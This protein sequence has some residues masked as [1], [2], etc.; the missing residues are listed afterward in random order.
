MV[1]TKFIAISNESR[2]NMLV[3][4]RNAEQACCMS[5]ILS[6]AKQYEQQNGKVHVWAYGRNRLY[7][8]YKNSHFQDMNVCEGIEAISAAIKAVKE[9]IEKKIAGNELYILIGMEQICS[10]FDL[11]DFTN[12]KKSNSLAISNTLTAKSEEQIKALEDMH[13][14]YGELENAIDEMMM[15]WIEKGKSNEEIQEEM[16]RMTAEFEKNHKREPVENDQLFEHRELDV[17]GEDNSDDVNEQISAYNALNDF[18]YIVTQGSRMGYHFMLCVNNYSDIVAT[19]LKVNLFNHRLAFQISADDSIAFFGSKIGS[20]LPEHICQYSNSLEDFSFR[21][22]LHK[23]IEWDGW[24]VDD[25]GKV[26][27]PDAL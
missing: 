27:N 10:D 19:K 12:T 22:Y 15:D 20:K 2:E 8:Y 4:A 13:N 18:I 23:G 17:K 9:R 26:I 6:A 25:D 11:I 21:P 16:K 24:E 3:I 7:Q 14:I 1:E 5:M